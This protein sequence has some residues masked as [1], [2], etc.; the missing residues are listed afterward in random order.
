MNHYFIKKIILFFCLISLFKI[1]SQY[2]PE[3]T[4]VWDPEPNI[5]NPGNNNQPPSDAIILFD[6]KDLS[7]WKGSSSH[8]FY[9]FNARNWS[10]INYRWIICCS[11]VGIIT[12]I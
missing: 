12:N 9:Y 8:T 5:I 11:C 1:N 3:D 7:K 6:G 10:N 2:K 4:E